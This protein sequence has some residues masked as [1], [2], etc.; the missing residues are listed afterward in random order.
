LK[1][2]PVPSTIFA[3]LG[4]AALPEPFSVHNGDEGRGQLKNRR[5][6]LYNS[7]VQLKKGSEFLLTRLRCVPLKG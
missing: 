1:G 3:H 4:D 2:T 5:F 6:M 7:L